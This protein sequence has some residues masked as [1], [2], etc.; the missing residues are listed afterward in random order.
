[1][2]FKMKFTNI[3]HAYNAHF[4][5]PRPSFTNIHASYYYTTGSK[6]EIGLTFGRISTVKTFWYKAYGQGTPRRLQLL[7]VNTTSALRTYKPPTDHLTDPLAADRLPI[8]TYLSRAV[9]VTPP[10]LPYDQC[11]WVIYKSLQPPKYGLAGT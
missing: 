5:L 11:H 9:C 10:L 4:T 1:M 6:L 2:Y 3:C 7:V 8:P